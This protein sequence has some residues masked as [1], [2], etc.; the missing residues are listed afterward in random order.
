MRGGLETKAL[1]TQCRPSVLSL[2]MFYSC[3]RQGSYVVLRGEKKLGYET[4]AEMI[5]LLHFSLS[6]RFAVGV[7]QTLPQVRPLTIVSNRWQL[8]SYGVK[9]TVVITGLKPQAE[10]CHVCGKLRGPTCVSKTYD[11]PCY[12]T[13][14]TA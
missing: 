8:F 14:F 10:P 12:I 9:F 5:D 1:N 11:T 4:V 7:C 13:A 3:S 2:Q 6:V